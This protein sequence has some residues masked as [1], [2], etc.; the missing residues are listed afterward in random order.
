VRCNQNITLNHLTLNEVYFPTDTTLDYPDSL[1]SLTHKLLKIPKTFGSLKLSY[2]DTRI[3]ENCNQPVRIRRQWSLED[4]CTSQVRS[5]TTTMNIHRYFNNFKHLNSQSDAIC[6]DEGFIS[7]TPVGEFT[8]YK[9][10]WSTGDSLPSIFGKPH[11][12]YTLTVTDRFGCTVSMIYNL[13]SMSQRADIGGRIITDIGIRVVPDS[14]IMENPNLVS[15]LCISEQSGI[16]YGFTLKNRTTGQYN[17]RFVK[18]SEPR[19]GISTKDIVM[20]QRHILGLAKFTDTLQNIAADV[21]YNFNITASDVTE[22]RRLILGIKETFTVVKPWY[23]FRR[24]WRSVAKP[25]KP[26]QDIEF[27]GINVPNF[28]LT[29]V[30]VFAMKMGDIDLSYNG[31]NN[32][33]LETRN[34]SDDVQLYFGNT[35]A[36]SDKWIPVYLKSTQNINGIQFKLKNIAGIPVRTKEFQLDKSFLHLDQNSLILSWS[37][38][39]VLQWNQDKPLFYLYSEKNI[40]DFK[41]DNSFSAEWYDH[42]LNVFHISSIQKEKVSDLYENALFYPNP[43]KDNIYFYQKFDQLEIKLYNLDGKLIDALTL[44]KNA[45]LNLKKYNQGTYLLSVKFRD[46]R[47][48]NNLLDILK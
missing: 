44:Y 10:K 33:E 18:N 32:S 45:A 20:I 9:Y 29:N 5:V 30:D 13:L 11:G 14:I 16:H 38:G 47:Q 7:L 42:D 40:E 4:L 39:H 25:N 36:S 3:S 37:T 17:Y 43:S 19:A 28:P 41:L 12:S 8:P 26:I 48:I 21:N 2:F 34:Y 23:F 31:L 27:A 22:I 6:L 35:M 15:K 1:T 24:D 46:G